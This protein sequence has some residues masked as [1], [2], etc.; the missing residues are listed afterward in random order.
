MSGKWASTNRPVRPSVSVYTGWKCDKVRE[1]GGVTVRVVAA[2]LISR[3]QAGDGDAF[4]ELTEPYRRELQVHCY[5][6][7]GS[8]QDAEDAL[9]DTLLAAWQGLGGFEVRA[10]LR[11]WLYRIATNRCLNARRSAS[12]RPAKEWDVPDV[13]PPEPT[14]L[15]EVVWLQPLPD[16]LLDG[17]IDVPLGPEARYEQ[18]ESISLAFVTAL[19]LLPPRQLAV[20]ILRDVLGFHAN[21]V[22]DMLDSTVE[23]VNSA[24]KRARAGLERQRPP[25]GDREPPPASN[26]R[27]EDAIVARFVRAYESADLDAL[28]ALLTDDVF[29]SMPPMPFEYQGRDVAVR[30]CASIFAAGR[31]FDLVRTR[32]NGQ[33]AFGAYLRGPAGIRHGIGLL[34]LTLTGDRICAI[35]RFDNSV[36]PWFGLPR[37]LPPSR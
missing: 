15:G 33:P 18:S 27:S 32:A 2:E 16:A 7:L 9:Q 36:L 12:R 34:V 19:Q 4:R 5:R 25:I 22:A 35:A 26:S 37:S 29:I 11:T 20:L 3:A 23:S 14:R 6:M 8:F 28:V 17:A 10:S 30:F 1:E 13:E 24:L 31:R 21:E